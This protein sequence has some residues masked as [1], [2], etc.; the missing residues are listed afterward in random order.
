MMTGSASQSASVRPSTVTDAYR[1]TNHT[2][3]HIITSCCSRLVARGRSAAASLRVRL[4]ISTASRSAWACISLCKKC[5]FLYGYA[6]PNQPNN[7]S[8]GPRV[9][10]PNGTSISSIVFTARCYASAVLA[11][12]L[13]LSVRPSQVGVLLRR[14]NESKELVLACELPST[15]PTLY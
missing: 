8:L 13:C 5:P 15:R 9:H 4:R 11:M 3:A 12:A 1:T 6:G 10:N 7:G 2:R 14:L